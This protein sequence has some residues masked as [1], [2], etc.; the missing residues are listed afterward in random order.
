MAVC[1]VI[2]GR[3]ITVSDDENN[4]TT[5]QNKERIKLEKLLPNSHVF[6]TAWLAPVSDK[7]KVGEV[8]AV[9]AEGRIKVMHEVPVNEA[10]YYIVSKERFDSCAL[11]I[12]GAFFII[13]VFVAGTKNSTKVKK[14]DT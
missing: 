6:L 4:V 5:Y 12:L 9:H 1:G 3:L 8:S 11:V 13:V 14:A 7:G 2:Q 10:Q